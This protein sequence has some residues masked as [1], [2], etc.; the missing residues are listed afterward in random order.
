MKT[1]WLFI[2]LTFN[3]VGEPLRFDVPLPVPCHPGAFMAVEAVARRVRVQFECIKGG[4]EGTTWRI[5][6][7]RKEVSR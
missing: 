1:F 5:A 6:K 2:L 3:G 7:K 4:L